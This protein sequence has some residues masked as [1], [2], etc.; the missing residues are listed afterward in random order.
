MRRVYIRGQVNR[1]G[2]YIAPERVMPNAEKLRPRGSGVSEGVNR[3]GYR[4]L[5]DDLIQI[6][7]GIESELI[8]TCTMVTNE[9][10]GRAPQ[11]SSRG[12]FE[13][14]DGRVYIT[15]FIRL[16]SLCSDFESDESKLIASTI[17]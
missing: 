8:L 3:E 15:V 16:Y 1:R 13:L 6:A 2:S 14:K 4:T 11:Y 12:I 7:E 17:G 9:S 10:E 5:E